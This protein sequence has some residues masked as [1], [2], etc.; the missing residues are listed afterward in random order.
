V[1]AVLDLLRNLLLQPLHSMLPPVSLPWRVAITLIPIVAVLF[2]LVPSL[3]TWTGRGV[4]SVVML[5]VRCYAW[6][7]Y[8][9][10]SV[11]RRSGRAPARL[12]EVVDD[13]AEALLR[14]VDRAAMAAASSGALRRIVRTALVAIVVVPVVSWQLAPSAQ[15][16]TVPA[17]AS[18]KGVAWSTSFDTWIRTGSGRHARTTWLE[19]KASPEKARRGGTITFT[20]QLRV[21][22]TNKGVIACPRKRIAFYTKEVGRASRQVGWTNTDSAGRFTHRFKATRSL[23]WVAR[24]DSTK[25][26]A[27]SEKRQY[28]PVA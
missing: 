15:P 9:I 12:V 24:F 23:N 17:V 11:A 13:C 18:A 1:T 22:D 6:I 21:L 5:I 8:R 20:G 3:L 19:L 16:G 2:L 14:G 28:V 26:L 7:E 25:E 10:V 27:A 4:S